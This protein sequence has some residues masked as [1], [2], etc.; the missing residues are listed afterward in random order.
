MTAKW[1]TTI[2][3]QEDVVKKVDNLVKDG[4]LEYKSRS[5]FAVKAIEKEVEYA[6]MLQ[7]LDHIS[8]WRYRDL[9]NSEKWKIYDICHRQTLERMEPISMD[10]LIEQ[11]KSIDKIEV[12]QKNKK[13]KN[14]KELSSNG[15]G[16][17]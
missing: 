1:N 8:R 14:K 5:D 6:S 13:T 4:S 3:L 9:Y 10:G 15:H 17:S 7:K 16:L 11:Q 12:T 2:K